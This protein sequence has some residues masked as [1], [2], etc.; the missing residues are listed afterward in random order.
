MTNKTTRHG[1]RTESSTETPD[2]NTDTERD[3]QTL[4]RHAGPLA[5]ADQKQQRVQGPGGSPLVPAA[6]ALRVHGAWPRPAF[7]SAAQRCSVPRLSLLQAADCK[8]LWIPGN[9]WPL[10]GGG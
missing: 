1:T 7:S 9:L 5:R 8:H 3:T 2:G 6:P 4:R 10:R